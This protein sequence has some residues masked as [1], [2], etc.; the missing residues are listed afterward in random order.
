[1]TTF[2]DLIKELAYHVGDV[3]QSV[4]TGGSVTTLVDTALNEAE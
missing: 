3:R 2:Y 4:S 1:M